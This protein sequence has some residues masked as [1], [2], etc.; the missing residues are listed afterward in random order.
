MAFKIESRRYTGSK[1]K[2]ADWIMSLISEHCS[3]EIFTDIFAGTGVIAAVA[4]K[5][6]K[7]VIVN[8]FLFSN[9]VIYQGFF[10][11]GQWSRDKL[12]KIIE[13]YNSIE[14]VGIKDNYFSKN[15]GGK[16]FSKNV[17]KTIGFIRDDI[18]KSR[19]NLKTK[20]Y[21]ILLASL[22][23]ST[24]KVANTVGHYDAYIQKPPDKDRLILEIIEPIDIGKVNIYRK[25][26][27]LL[28]KNL[29]SDV[30]Y[31]DP[32]YNSRQY[33]RFYHV[34]ETLTKWDEPKLY[35]VALKPAHENM[36]DYCKVK[37]VDKLA[38]LI[39]SLNCSYI[40]FSYNNTYN[41]KSNSSKSKIKLEQ[42]K[43]ILEKKGT[44]NMFQK[45]H[46]YFNC[47]KTEFTN[48]QERLFI[49]K[50]S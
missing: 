10:G 30:V 44:T 41:P 4:S 13:K 49:T 22:I 42:I 33:S 40:V 47:G 2:L 7:H 9:H 20:E 25:D 31:I 37:A 23:Y 6:F 3:G 5:S 8:D 24:D 45:S 43:Q 29:K 16:Y 48:H 39:N 46:R 35:G 19:Q 14:P 34:L 36:S 11:K 18:E 28:A 12:N 27:N 1:A 38:D 21:F 26:T 32:P 17:A 15:F 50:V